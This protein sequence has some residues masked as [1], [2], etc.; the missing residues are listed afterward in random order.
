MPV[1]HFA[2]PADLGWLKRFKEINMSDTEF[3]ASAQVAQT[4]AA[5][6]KRLGEIIEAIIGD[7]RVRELFDKAGKHPEEYEG[8]PTGL[9]ALDLKVITPD[10]KN[11]LLVAQAAERAYMLAE[12]A[13]RIAAN[14]DSL[15]AGGAKT[16]APDIVAHDDPVFKFVG[17]DRDP[18]L[19]RR[20]Q[21]TWM[22]AQMLLNNEIQSVIGRIENA[23][24]VANPVSQ[25]PAAGE[26]FK[27]AAVE[28]YGEAAKIMCG[29]GHYA[30]AAKFNGVAQAL[31]QDVQAG[32]ASGEVMAALASDFSNGSQALADILNDDRYLAKQP[33]EAAFAKLGGLTTK[34]ADGS[35]PAP[36]PVIS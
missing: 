3:N 36:A 18:P 32:P 23:A 24:Y 10:T 13:G 34:P 27:Q 15:I 33:V 20:A 35:A 16:Y 19:L 31:A 5:M 14:H 6:G 21:G 25:G 22:A 7:A 28:L 12:K 4:R 11:A 2:A 29:Q 1:F 17:S 9:M 30:A 26:G 8:K